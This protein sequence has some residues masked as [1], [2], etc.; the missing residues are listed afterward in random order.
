IEKHIGR[1]KTLEESNKK[2]VKAVEAN[3]EKS[4]AES[5]RP[6]PTVKVMTQPL[7]KGTAFTRYVGAM[8]AAR[9]NRFEAAEFAKRWKDST[10]EVEAILRTPVDVIEKAAVN[11][12]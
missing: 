11:A 8:A 4:A 6:G 7:A 10:P 9:G 2:T 3:D 1:L 12:G 5:R